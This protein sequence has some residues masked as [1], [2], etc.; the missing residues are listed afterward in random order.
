MIGDVKYNDIKVG[1][2]EYDKRYSI[3]RLKKELMD[4]KGL[5]REGNHLFH[6]NADDIK[7]MLQRSYSQ[8]VTVKYESD[9]V[10][11]KIKINIE[12]NQPIL[13]SISYEGGGTH[14]CVAVGVECDKNDEPTKILCLDPGYPTPKFTYWNSVIDLKAFEGKYPY[15]NITESGDTHFIKLNDILIISKKN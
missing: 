11:D 1:G 9:S 4:V 8:W 6:E 14:A 12:N 15:K 2:K 3:E 10:I 7:K 5:H 13:I